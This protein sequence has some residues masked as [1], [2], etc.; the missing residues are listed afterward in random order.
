MSRIILPNAGIQRWTMAPHLLRRVESVAVEPPALDDLEDIGDWFS[1]H[2]PEDVFESAG[3]VTIWIDSSVDAGPG[4][5]NMFPANSPGAPD[6]IANGSGAFWSRQSA[7]TPHQ[8]VGV[9]CDVN[10]ST[11]DSWTHGMLFTAFTVE[12]FVVNSI[13]HLTPYCPPPAS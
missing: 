12:Q 4:T 7:L 11:F 8:G 9:S 10:R 3:D 2:F 13:E 1:Y 5:K 6:A